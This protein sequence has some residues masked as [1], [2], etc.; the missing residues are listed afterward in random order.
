MTRKC[1][2]L[3][4]TL[5]AATLGAAAKKPLTSESVW[6]MRTVG[7]PQITRDGKSIIFVLGWNDRMNDA[8][9]SNLWTVSSDG[10][11]Q[12]PITSGAFRDSSPSRACD[13][14]RTARDSSSPAIATSLSSPQR[15]AL[16]GRSP[17]VI[18]IMAADPAAGDSPGA[19][20]GRPFTLPPSASPMRI[21]RSKAGISTPSPLRTAASAS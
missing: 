21:T 8:S 6:D 4:G 3:I 15:A 14:A 10:K 16:P 1:A 12:R 13:G 7:D 5:A 11:D 17:T 20:M 18:S 19:P 2:I 9:Y